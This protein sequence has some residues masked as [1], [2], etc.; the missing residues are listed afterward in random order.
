MDRQEIKDY[1]TA[2]SE[3]ELPALQK[4]LSIGY[5]EAKSVVDEMIKAGKIEYVSG[6]KYRTNGVFVPSGGETVY[7]PADAHEAMC[8]KALWACINFDGVSVAA[9][10]RKLMLSFVEASA[11]VGWM[12]R[13]G[14]VSPRPHLKLLITR[15]EFIKKFGNPDGEEQ[16][17]TAEREKT[18]LEKAR[19]LWKYLNSDDDKNKPSDDKADK[20]DDGNGSGF[21]N[22]RFD[23]DG[24]VLLDGEDETDDD[25]DIDEEVRRFIEELEDD[26]DDDDDDEE[27]DFDFTGYEF[28]EDE[29]VLIGDD[30]DD[31][32]TDAKSILRK[33][34]T[35][36]L[37][38]LSNGNT[39]IM[40]LDGEPEYE[41]KFI[42]NGCAVTI[43]D[44][45]AT[46]GASTL[47]RRRIK[48]ILKSR[49]PVELNGDAIEITVENPFG[50]LMG[51][52]RLYAAIDAVRRAE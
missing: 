29:C 28:D 43:S 38:E 3:V 36:C 22:C 33:S 37:A 44:R 23:Q 19:E 21:K 1:I 18:E 51:L 9:L 34:M 48:N 32:G 11:A 46:V 45:G 31:D 17:P 47:T 13:N 12:E 40:N 39:C 10:Q 27:A 42:R 30:D 52:M 15:E 14:L 26:D 8:I 41:L 5:A 25:D 2:R 50:L 20:A 35:G 24:N 49:A 16:S 4:D 7:K 6:V